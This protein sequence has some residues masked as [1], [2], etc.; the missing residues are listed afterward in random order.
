MPT[1]VELKKKLIA[2]I[3]STDDAELLR[4][5]SR[6]FDF[7]EQVENVYEMSPEEIEAVNIGLDQISKGLFLSNKESNKRVDE[8][9]EK[10]ADQ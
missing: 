8:W 9:L 10:H 6:V 3:K 1:D 2:K 7:E 5:L 4:Q